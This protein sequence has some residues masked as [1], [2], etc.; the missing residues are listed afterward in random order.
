MKKIIPG[1]FFILI[2]IFSFSCSKQENS[3]LT[4]S[5]DILP[6][7][8]VSA[9][10]YIYFIKKIAQETVEAKTL[11]PI[12]FNPHFFEPT[13]NQ[14]SLVL[15]ADIWF[16]TGEGFERSILKF[17][18]EKKTNIIISDLRDHIELI[19][20][21][22]STC[23]CKEDID[24]KDVHIWTSPRLAKIQ[25]K[26]IASTLIEKY[27]EKK[28]F[29]LKNLDS[30]L[31]ELDQLDKE[32]ETK[33]KP[34]SGSSFLISHPAYGY[35]CKDYHLEQISVEYEGKEPTLKI[36]SQTFERAKQKNIKKIFIQAQYNNKGAEYIA[37]KMGLSI[38]M[39]DPYSVDYIENIKKFVDAL[40]S[41]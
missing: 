8:I 3:K 1:Y 20:Y 12:N 15:S 36:L 22:N 4:Q 18:K 21:E 32:I 31:N 23:P 41:E 9:S 40:L 2:C 13:F 27:P 28:N 17:L 39:V 26:T 25:A 35:F 10:P 29:Y 19:P 24:F 38:S 37:K 14:V 16:K 33:L 11:I 30:F 34:L 6:T 5:K 7:V